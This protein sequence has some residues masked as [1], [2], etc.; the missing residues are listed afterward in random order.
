[1]LS[2]EQQVEKAVRDYFGDQVSLSFFDERND[3][4]HF[5]IKIVSD[6]FVW[7][8]RVERSQIVYRVLDSFLKDNTIHALRMECKAP[9]E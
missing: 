7:K 6:L 2:V 3:G 8:G 9:G 4:K 1:M 5:F